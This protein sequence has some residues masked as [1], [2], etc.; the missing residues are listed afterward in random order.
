[1]LKHLAHCNPDRPDFSPDEVDEAYQALRVTWRDLKTELLNASV[2]GRLP[3][4]RLNP[5]ID[6]LRMMLRLAERATRIA[7]RL[8]E[9]GRAVPAVAGKVAADV[10]AGTNEPTS[11][12]GAD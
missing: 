4:Q 5:A 1:M 3:V 9:L 10:A 11:A 7:V 2:R 8:T 12:I 6:S